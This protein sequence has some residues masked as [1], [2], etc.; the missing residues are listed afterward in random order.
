MSWSPITT[1]PG[2]LHIKWFF[3]FEEFNSSYQVPSEVG[4]G[5]PHCREG[6]PAAKEAAREDEEDVPPLD[7]EHRVEEIGDVAT[8]ALRDVWTGDPDEAFNNIFQRVKWAHAKVMIT[9]I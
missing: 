8:A 7:V 4:N 5:V 1:R 3:C 2:L 9:P 6:E